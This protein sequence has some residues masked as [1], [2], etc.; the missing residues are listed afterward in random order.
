MK[1]TIVSGIIM[2]LMGV[3]VLS[4]S[5]MAAEQGNVNPLHWIEREKIR[6][7][8]TPERFEQYG[9]MKQA[10][11]NAVMPRL[12]LDVTTVYD[13]SKVSVALSERDGQIMSDLLKGSSLAKE[14]G[15]HYFH[16]LGI[17]CE[18]QTYIE[19]FKDNPA[20]FN[21]GTIPSPVDP[22]YWKRVILDRADRALRLLADRDKYA[23]DAIIIDP[24]MYALNAS[25]PGEAD[26]GT[27]AFEKFMKETGR[28]I[29]A[30]ARD[31][32]SRRKWLEDQKLDAEYVRWQFNCVRDFGKQLRELVDKY[33]PDVILGYIIYEDRMW[34]N[35]MAAGL[36]TEAVPV[37]VGP[38]ST[39]SGVMDQSMI[40]YIASMKASIGVPCFLTPGV[41]MGLAGGKV[42]HER[43]KVLEGNVYQ[44][45]R[46]S[47][48]YFVYAIYNFGN[49]D[50][51]QGA[52]FN[53]LKVINDALDEQA[54][55]G[56]A[57]AVLKAAPLPV[58]VPKGFESL[59][60][61]AARMK[62]VPMDVPRARFPFEAP[63]LRAW[64]AAD[65]P[66][67]IGSYVLLL[68]PDPH[69]RQAVT[70]RTIK[71]GN[72]VDPCAVQLFTG[73]GSLIW[74]TPVANNE[75]R[76]LWL[77]DAAGT[78]CA[79]LMGAGSNAFTI[80]QVDCP[81]MIYAEELLAVNAQKG[82]AGRFYFYVPQDRRQFGL[83]LIGDGSETA[84]YTLF[85][86]AGRAVRQWKTLK[87]TQTENI[88]VT[89]PGI[90]CIQVDYLLD[91]GGFGLVDL[92]N[93]FAL[94]PEDVRIPTRQ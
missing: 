43:L 49:T 70:I 65:L 90:W 37:F 17:A 41:D 75:R 11:M 24:E 14:L 56:K 80:E 92:P 69:Q 48:G 1:R 62:P 23:L 5:V 31:V 60:A 52:F 53:S 45:C 44:R 51:E 50:E 13:P 61:E 35:A 93:L 2:G 58:A 66:G 30:E 10:G 9:M 71:L 57:S 29:P 3:A 86:S 8:W 12:E 20:R 25:L 34:F 26:Y 7:G 15:L 36:S 16:C 47:A 32:A 46:H 22:V 68:W 73:Q 19:G 63:K 88:A 54:K 82:P 72:Y 55:T 85:D 74:D 28:R 78:F 77:P 81:A 4:N 21:D 40:D 84:D 87:Q 94:R 38:E 83:K 59:L 6:M 33:R 64:Y 27:F 18:S 39:Y 67:P 79:Q 89:Q 42:P 91:D 76:A